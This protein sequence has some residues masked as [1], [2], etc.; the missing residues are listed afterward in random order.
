[1]GN[2]LALF[3]LRHSR[4][5][6]FWYADKS[7]Y[8]KYILM[9]HKV[10]EFIF[11]ESR[12]LRLDISDVVIY[13]SK[14][15]KIDLHTAKPGLVLGKGGA[16]IN[17]IRAKVAAL[18]QMDVSDVNI[19]LVSINKPE[20]NA[21][22]IALRVAQD[23]E[24]RRSYNHSM[25]SHVQDAMRFGAL[26]SRIECSGRLNGVEI[27]RK[28][29]NSQG[30]VPRQTIRANVFYCSETAFTNSGTCGVK[31]WVNLPLN[32]TKKHTKEPSDLP[33]QS[34]NPQKHYKRPLN[35]DSNKVESG[36]GE[37]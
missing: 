12:N 35:S 4:Y 3:D 8:S 21:K 37:R 11:R 15:I 28:S 1:M 14:S 25:R 30:K 17:A 9:N 27:A 32:H 7:N 26:G 2:K 34:N 31:V 36:K 23:L 33:L 20:L 10:R 18:L 13:G 22:I 5:K 16:N 6:S 19:N 24:R 29:V